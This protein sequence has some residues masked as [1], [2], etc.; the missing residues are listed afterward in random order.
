M[1][2]WAYVA[3]LFGDGLYSLNS[4]GADVYWVQPKGFLASF[5]DE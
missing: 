1:R 2:Q 3:S 5:D 4:M